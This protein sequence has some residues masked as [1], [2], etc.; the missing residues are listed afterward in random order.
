M[1]Y[2]LIGTDGKCFC[3]CAMKC[4]KGKTGMQYRCTKEDI[5]EEGFKTIQVSDKKSNAAV[6]DSLVCDGR[7]H[8][9]KI[10]DIS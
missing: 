6:M 1:S 4:I 2:I 9:L 10:K 3:N 5:E 8:T 7:D